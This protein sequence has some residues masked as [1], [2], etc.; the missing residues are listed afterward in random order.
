[1]SAS[2]VVVHADDVAAQHGVFRALTK[3]LKAEGIAINRLELPP[4]EAGP[5]HHHREDAQQE[6]YAVVSGSGLLRVDGEEIPLRPG[7]FVLCLP[8]AQRQMIA[9]EDG[10]IW[11][12]IGTSTGS[13]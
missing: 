5:D 6:I 10:L 7:H 12:G 11:I 9:G 3:P 4:G 2:H 13:E 1:M 8:E